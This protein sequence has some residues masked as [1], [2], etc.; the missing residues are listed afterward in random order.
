[1][2]LPFNFANLKNILI[3]GLILV[4]GVLCAEIYFKDRKI[5]EKNKEIKTLEN[6]IKL[7]TD[8]YIKSKQEQERDAKIYESKKAELEKKLQAKTT[9]IQNYKGESNDDCKNTNSLFGNY[10]F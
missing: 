1:M 10:A 4:I 9:K 2:F 8:E 5:E 6:S 3:A 7:L